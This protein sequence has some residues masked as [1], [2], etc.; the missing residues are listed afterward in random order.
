MKNKPIQPCPDTRDLPESE[1]L[2]LL[3]R[4]GEF[5]LVDG[6]EIPTYTYA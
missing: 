1:M 4:A 2:W 5:D 3:G 6:V